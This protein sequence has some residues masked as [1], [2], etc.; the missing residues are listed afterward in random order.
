MSCE[1]NCVILQFCAES[2]I[3]MEIRHILCVISF[4]YFSGARFTGLQ[5]SPY[6][7]KVSAMLNTCSLIAAFKASRFVCSA[8]A[9]NELTISSIRSTS[10]KKVFDN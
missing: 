1:I 5:I 7:Y 8:L 3:T 9:F 10:A 6:N 2:C 4:C